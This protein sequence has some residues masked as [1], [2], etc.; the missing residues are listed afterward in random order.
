MVAI[1]INRD[2]DSLDDIFAEII[3]TSS[4]QPTIRNPR[5]ATE[6]LKRH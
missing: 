4:I 6:I 5:S 2:R 1:R 3:A